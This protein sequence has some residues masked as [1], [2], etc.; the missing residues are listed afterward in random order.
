M[1]TQ[2]RAIL[3][4]LLWLTPV[5]AADEVRRLTAF[6]EGR[7]LE[8]AAFAKRGAS[9]DDLSFAAR[10]LLA[11]AMSAHDNAL[12]QD[13]VIEAEDLARRAVA[14]APDHVEARLQLAIALSL[15]LRP[16]SAREAL[17]KGYGSVAKDLAETVLE[18][19]PHNVYAHGF[20]SIWHIE[21]VRRG[22]SMGAAFMG[23]SVKQARRHYHGAIGA[24]PDE[25]ATHWQYAKA[26]TALNAKKYR[27][28][29]DA[30]LA[31]ALS[32]QPDN[33]LERLMQSRAE[34]LHA[35]FQTQTRKEVEQ[36]AAEML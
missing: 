27:K 17:Q 35:A 15:R 25:A 3:C 9:P 6:G 32:A 18:D 14:I 29:I 22:G 4:L 26:L 21:V 28:E 12:H 13:T 19:D 11:N 34:I 20:M 10:C 23:A 7:Y 2:M 16:L 5:A 1:L 36:L 24:D 8:A 33:E 30:A 31:A